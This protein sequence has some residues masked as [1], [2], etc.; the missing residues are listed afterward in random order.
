MFATSPDCFIASSSIVPYRRA[1]WRDFWKTYAD[2]C[3]NSSVPIWSV[4]ARTVPCCTE[5]IAPRGPEAKWKQV[6]RIPESGP[7]GINNMGFQITLQCRHYSLA[8]DSFIES[9]GVLKA[10]LYCYDS[11]RSDRA[12]CTLPFKGLKNG[13]AHRIEPCFLGSVDKRQHDHFA[14]HWNHQ[15]LTIQ[16]DYWWQPPLK[17]SP[18]GDCDVINMINNVRNHVVQRVKD[19]FKEAEAKRYRTHRTRKKEKTKSLLIRAAASGVVGMSFR[20]LYTQNRHQTN[21][22]EA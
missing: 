12:P 22:N 21:K 11:H 10:A 6:F 15:D 2:G 8:S 20:A 19:D 14:R 9:Y 1:A 16:E 13:S 3:C 7:Y 4:S 18:I 17:H 5:E